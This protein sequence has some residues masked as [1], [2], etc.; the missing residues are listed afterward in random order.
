[1][2]LF[3]FKRDK[4]KRMKNIGLKY[5]ENLRSAKICKMSICLIG[6]FDSDMQKGKG[7]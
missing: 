4:E 2:F 1:M 6:T 3:L 5:T 7:Q